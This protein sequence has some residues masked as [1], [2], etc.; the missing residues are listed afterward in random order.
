MGDG[1]QP[2]L[3]KRIAVNLVRFE[4]RRR[5]APRIFAERF[6]DRAYSLIGA[7]QKPQIKHCL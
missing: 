6:Q 4:A 7:F 5:V 3:C 2:S 1:F